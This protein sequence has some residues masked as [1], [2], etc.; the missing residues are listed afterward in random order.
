[1]RVYLAG[2]ITAD[3]STHAW[4]ATACEHLRNNGHVP[5]SPMRRKDPKEISPNGL[6][7]DISPMLFVE[8]DEKDIRSADMMIINALGMDKLKRQSIGTWAEMG[9]ARILHLPIILIATHHDVTTY[10]FIL[11]WAC[12]VVPDLQHALDVVDWLAD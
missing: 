11:K 4:R 7:S 8:R 5:L 9:M 12:A 10:P 2:T 6:T 1:M 3:P